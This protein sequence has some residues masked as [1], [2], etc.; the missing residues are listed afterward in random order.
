MVNMEG[1][2]KQMII[3]NAAISLSE[4]DIG[5]ET[6]LVNDLGFDSV[7]V[8]RFL[9]EVET[10]FGFEFDDDYLSLE[11]LGKYKKLKDAVDEKMK[12]G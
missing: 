7:Q 10:E 11:I 4:D 8:M 6:D 3:R 5:S 2:L 12:N 9:T 1:R